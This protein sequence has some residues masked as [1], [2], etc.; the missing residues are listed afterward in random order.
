LQNLPNQKFVINLGFG[1]NII[2]GTPNEH[3][4]FISRVRNADLE[5]KISEGDRIISVS[6]MSGC[7]IN[8]MQLFFKVNG[9]SM[10]AITLDEAV[11]ILNQL[12]GE[13][14]FKIQANVFASLHLNDTQK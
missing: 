7:Q 12:E 2:G 5:N 11:K 3:A 13:C 14:E 9:T 4:I 10:E 8:L 6:F 1:F